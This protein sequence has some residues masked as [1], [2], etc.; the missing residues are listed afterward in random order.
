MEES[1]ASHVTCCLDLFSNAVDVSEAS[2]PGPEASFNRSI[3]DEQTRFKVWSGNIGAHRTGMSSLDHRLRDSSNIRNQVV[4]LL[5]DLNGLL[6]DAI[7][8]LT[9]EEP[10]WDQISNDGGVSLDQDDDDS[11]SPDTELEQISIDVADVVNCLLRLSVAI[12]NPAPHDRFVE[13]HSTDTSHYE[14]FDIEHVYS[15]FKSIDPGLAQRLG[16]AISRRRQFF[17]Y[18]EAHRMKLS[19]GLDYQYLGDAETIASSLPE[20]LKDK[21]RTGQI[22]RLPI[23]EDNYSDAGVSQTSYATSAADTEQRRVPPLPTEASKGPFECPF[24]FTIIAA[25]DRITW[26]KHVYGDLRPYVC[27]YKNCMTPEKEFSRRHQWMDHV[28]Q[29]HWKSHAGAGTPQELA[30]MISLSEQPL[31]IRS[32]ISC[33]ICGVNLNSARRYQSHVGRHQEQLALF[34]LP[35]LESNEQADTEDEGQSDVT[36]IGAKSDHSET[37][38][39]EDAPMKEPPL[40]S[41]PREIPDHSEVPNYGKQNEYFVP[42]DGIDREVIT[43]D[44]CLHLRNDAVVRPGHYESNTAIRRRIS[45]VRYTARP[46]DNKMILFHV[47]MCL[48]ETSTDD[49]ASNSQKRS[50]LRMSILPR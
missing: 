20:H 39:N 26:K 11:D 48:R 46:K 23:I 30:A 8:I 3:R 27:L 29:N 6:E 16:K 1:I 18:R 17:K 2:S 38:R 9:G 34:A 35:T 44:I 40:T 47:R 49:R 14:R 31:D 41:S 28:K 5:L 25:T 7:A 22:S 33:P 42:R 43:A 21:V 12:R 13:S 15:K 19:H 50:G 37:R 4:N 36:S 32:G 24:C 10:S 45:R